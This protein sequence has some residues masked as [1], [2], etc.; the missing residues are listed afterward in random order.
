MPDFKE[1]P[2]TYFVQDR[3]SVDE[4]TRLSLQDKML[5]TGMG[6]VL[7]ELA[8]P[9]QLRRVLDVGCG[10]GGWLI[11][12]A[13]TYPTIERLVGVDISDQMC[14]CSS[15]VAEVA[16]L[17][18]RVQF[19]TMDAL[20]ILDFP[21]A[22]FDLVNQ[23]LGFSW[24]RTWEWKKILYEYQ[25]VCRPGGIIRVTE[26]NI[27]AAYQN[28]PALAKLN[29]LTL[30]ANYHA[31]RLFAN[32]S[33]GITSELPILM[34]RHGCRNIQ[35]RVHT[36]VYRARTASALRFSE[37]MALFYRVARPYFQKWV[38]VP[39]NYDELYQQALVEM[40]SREFA[41]TSTLLTVWGTPNDQSLLRQGG[42]R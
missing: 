34:A 25:R 6:G 40:Q 16:H 1:H 28:A 14:S 18:T 29:A 26:P 33:D 8:D 36:F 35:S 5:T 30:E 42:L 17:D 9:G 37:D 11:E 19:Q 38:N 10:T 15:A 31:G 2:S 24:L 4:M 39:D 22:S 32:R 23:R 7:P 41:V 20:R 21:D 3:E 13:Q 12:T 27:L